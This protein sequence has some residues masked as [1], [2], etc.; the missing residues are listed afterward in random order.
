[1]SREPRLSTS[2]GAAAFAPSRQALTLSG[3]QL[4]EGALE[5]LDRGVEQPG[6]VVEHARRWRRTCP[7]GRTAPAPPATA[8]SLSAARRHVADHAGDRAAVVGLDLGHPLRGAVERRRPGRLPRR[9]GRPARGRAPIPRRSRSPRRPRASPSSVLRFGV[10]QVVV[11]RCVRRR[12]GSPGRRRASRPGPG[13]RG[14][15]DRRRPR[16]PRARRPDASQVGLLPRRRH[17]ADRRQQPRTTPRAAGR[18]PSASSGSTAAASASSDSATPEA[19]AHPVPPPQRLARAR[20]LPRGCGPPRRRRRPVRRSRSRPGAGPRSRPPDRSGSESKSRAAASRSP[21][22]SA[23]APRTQ[24]GG[25]QPH[26]VGER[27]QLQRP[28]GQR[29]GRRPGAA[30]RAP[31]TACEHRT[32]AISAGAPNSCATVRA[33]SRAARRRPAGRGAAASRPAGAARGRAPGG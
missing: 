18:R 23:T 26:R 9:S 25:D 31:S 6:A 33:R 13:Q 29:R 17:G 16:R 28:V 12:A 5:R 7:A 27:R 2:A 22:R 8:R 15:L 30:A 32:P 14:A 21:S 3:E 19:V 20:R 4:V 24:R 11:R 1:M 10:G